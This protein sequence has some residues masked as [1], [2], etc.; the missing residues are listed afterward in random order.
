[1]SI[2]LFF[3]AHRRFKKKT[4]L[5]QS[6]VFDKSQKIPLTCIFYSKDLNT[7]SVSLKAAFS[8]DI[9]FPKPR[10]SVTSM[11]L[12]CRCWLHLLCKAL[13]NTLITTVNNEMGL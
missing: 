9:P 6:K 11:L 2:C 8:V 1:M 10:S 13:S 12:V 5:V 3:I 4:A 7:L